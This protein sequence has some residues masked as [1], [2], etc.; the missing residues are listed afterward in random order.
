MA[1]IFTDE[2]N[3]YIVIPLSEIITR[4]DEPISDRRITESGEARVTN[5]QENRS[6]VNE[7]T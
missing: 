6:I 5:D 7:S 4:T 2:D 1:Q 3:L